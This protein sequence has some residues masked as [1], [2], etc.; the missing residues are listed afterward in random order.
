EARP[1]VPRE[2]YR[3]PG[4][5]GGDVGATR[6]AHALVG[7]LSHPM[8]VRASRGRLPG[9][10]RGSAAARRG[11][12]RGL[13]RPHRGRSRRPHA[14]SGA[15]LRRAGVNLAWGTYRAVAPLMGAAAPLAGRIAPAA[16]RALWRERLGDVPDEAP[17]DA[18]IHGASLGEAVAVAGLL[19]ELRA[20]A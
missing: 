14:R 17:V 10:A 15:S 12:D 3:I 13:A 7:W 11:R 4:A 5:P 18:W 9:P 2:S 16:E 20:Q 19:A 6:V 1:G 8:S